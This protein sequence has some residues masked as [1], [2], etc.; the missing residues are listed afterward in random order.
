MHLVRVDVARE[1]DVTIDRVAVEQP[2]ITAR[3][4]LQKRRDVRRGEIRR[5]AGD[6]LGD[7]GLRPLDQLVAVL[8]RQVIVRVDVE[9]PE[10]L[11]FPRRQGVEA[12]RLDVRERHQAEQLEPLFDAD[13]LRERA[14]D[15]GVFG[16]APERHLRHAQMVRDEEQDGVARLRG[17]TQPIEERFRHPH[18]LARVVLF[19]PLADVVEEER[20]HEELRRLEVAEQRG[21]TLAP[22][23]DVAGHLGPAGAGRRREPLQVA[24]GQQRVLVN[25]VLVVE[26]AH[27]AGRNRLQRWQHP[28]EQPGVVHFGQP[29]VQPGTRLQKREQRRAVFVGGK[30]ILR[31]EPIDRPL[32]ARERFV[33]DD[34]AGVERGLKRAEP[35][36]GLNRRLALVHEPNP[37]AR[38]ADVTPIGTGAVRRARSSTRLTAFA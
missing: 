5:A 4:P 29:R 25:R 17:Q 35:R 37:V 19:P 18:A 30:K 32:D 15:F 11:L 12:H 33:G 26:V 16:V 38:A 13:Q 24:D 20:E 8:E 10:Q 31:L 21:E 9:P 23:R 22:R 27:D 2:Q 34:G 1:A 7:A 28:R 3:Q 36:R 6:T 14:D